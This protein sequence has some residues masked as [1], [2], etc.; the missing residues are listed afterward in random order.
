MWRIKDEPHYFFIKR[1][2]E[3]FETRQYGL[4]IKVTLKTVSAHVCIMLVTRI[5]FI[6]CECFNKRAFLKF[7]HSWILS[8]NVDNSAVINWFPNAVTLIWGTASR[9]NITCNSCLAIN[10]FR[11]DIKTERD[12]N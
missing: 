12:T 2:S 8:T 6:I 11:F 3:Y 9:F 5:S 4:D 7:Y 10:T 1:F